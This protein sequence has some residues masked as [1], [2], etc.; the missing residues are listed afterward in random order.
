M[1]IRRI[2]GRRIRGLRRIRYGPPDIV[3]LR[4][5]DG[6]LNSEASRVSYLSW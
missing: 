3:F 6:H 2:F 4:G 1:S 5:D